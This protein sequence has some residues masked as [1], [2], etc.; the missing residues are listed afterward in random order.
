MPECSAC[1]IRSFVAHAHAIWM[2]ITFT[3]TRT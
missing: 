2:T 1:G 3:R